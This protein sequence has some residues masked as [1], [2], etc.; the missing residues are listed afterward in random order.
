MGFKCS[1]FLIPGRQPWYPHKL[2]HVQP[3]A[4]VALQQD[5]TCRNVEFKPRIAIHFMTNDVK[6]SNSTLDVTTMPHSR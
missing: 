5:V 3:S 1:K 6:Q 2:Q 4:M